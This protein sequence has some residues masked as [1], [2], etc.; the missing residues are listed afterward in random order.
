[1]LRTGGGSDS[2]HLMSLATASFE[3]MATYPARRLDAGGL[4]A[5]FAFFP[6]E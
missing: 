5:Y 4:I 3:M 6:T 1:M 2:P